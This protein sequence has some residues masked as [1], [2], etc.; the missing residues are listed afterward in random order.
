MSPEQPTPIVLIK[1]K[2]A[3]AA[4]EVQLTGPVPHARELPYNPNAKLAELTNKSSYTEISDLGHMFLI[5]GALTLFALSRL[6]RR[7]RYR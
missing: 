7:G 3:D 5:G 1:S 4:V 6:V 2:N